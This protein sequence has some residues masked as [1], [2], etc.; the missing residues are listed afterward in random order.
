MKKWSGTI[1]CIFI[2]YLLIALLPGCAMA[3]TVWEGE[4]VA[5]EY[6]RKQLEQKWQARIQF[7]LD[8]DVIPLID[9]ESSL[10]R[11]DGDKYLKAAMQVMDELGVALITF[12]GYQAPKKSK[13]QKGYRWGYYIHRIVNNYPDRFILASNG[14]TN[15]NWLKQKDSFVDQTEEHLKSGDYPIMGEFDF[16]HYMSNSQCKR[17]RK[18]RDTDIPIDSVNGRRIFVLSEET[19]IAFVI[20]HEPEDR[21]L[22]ELEM[23]LATHPK[24]KVIWAHFGQIRH[25]KK[26]KKFG[27]ELVRRLLSTYPN[28]YFEISTGHP[29]RR[30]KCNGSVL[31]TVIWQ[32]GDP[33]SQKKTLKP[34]YK[35]ILTEFSNRFV[36]G[37]DY[38]GGRRPLPE[39][40]KK[41]VKNVR[42]IMRDLP[43]EA[44]YNIGYRN[45][46][47]LLT[48][49]QYP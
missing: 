43:I 26:Q 1:K 30:Y 13:N 2:K 6:G 37:T 33:S 49:K 22:A 12:D 29:G 9:L 48:G 46:W 5:L 42:L 15:E 44:K 25:P 39:H 31:D 16:R 47:L 40:M 28:L 41:T 27:P 10:K 23:M 20:H 32:S 17:G 34:E 3:A 38:G 7:F 35:K 19:G 21:P 14:G 36:V 8:K 45:A 11:K 18:D 4:P 24:A